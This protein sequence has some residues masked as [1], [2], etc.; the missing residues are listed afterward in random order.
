MRPT[1]LI[2]VV[3][4]M[5]I[6]G[7]GQVEPVTMAVTM[8]DCVYQGQNQMSE[9][10]VSVSLSLNGITEATV[11]L[12]E[13]TDEHTYAELGQTI[14]S[15]LPSWAQPVVEVG[16]STSDALDGVEETVSVG[17]GDYALVCI[18]DSGIR[19]ATSLVVRES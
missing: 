7:C 15:G 3:A 2:I 14:G 13:L 5:S 9:G 12:V 4:A 1:H 11:V 18:D 17:P 8:P 16:L 19:L 6:A 10:D